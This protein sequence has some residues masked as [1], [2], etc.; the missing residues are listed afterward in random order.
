MS[1]EDDYLFTR[2]GNGKVSPEDVPEIV[3][4][5]RHFL[6]N[7]HTSVKFLSEIAKEANALSRKALDRLDDIT[8]VP[9]QRHIDGGGAIGRIESKVDATM[10]EVEEKIRNAV[11]WLKWGIGTVIAI[12]AIAA[13]VYASHR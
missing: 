11:N 13:A 6:I 1:D 4:A 3:R 2:M 10:T 8:G 12:A 7:E 5:M 9:G